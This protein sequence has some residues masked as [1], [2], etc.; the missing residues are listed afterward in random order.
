MRTLGWL[1]LIALTLAGPLA[2]AQSVDGV[3][4]G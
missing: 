3:W 2:F 1:L 4:E